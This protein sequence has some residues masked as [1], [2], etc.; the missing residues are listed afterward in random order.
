MTRGR[1]PKPAHLKLIEGNPGKRPIDEAKEIQP[2]AGDL[3]APP[4]VLCADG[5]EEW[6]RIAV[7]LR[8]LGLLTVVDH[9]ALAAYCAAFG[10]WI[11]AERALSKMRKRDELTAGLMIKTSNGNAVQ[12]PL[13]GVANKAAADMVRYAAEFGMTPAARARLALG[14]GERKPASKFDGLIGGAK[15][16]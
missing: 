7:Q 9:A 5:A 10:R 3:P 1:K 4:D 6:N 13:V 2:V 14:A 15:T 12:N 11:Q 8:N 16:P